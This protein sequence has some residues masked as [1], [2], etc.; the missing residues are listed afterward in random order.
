[1]LALLTDFHYHFKN[2][3]HF[4]LY[5]IYLSLVMNILLFFLTLY[6]QKTDSL[7]TERL[8]AVLVDTVKLQNV[9]LAINSTL[10]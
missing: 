1:M 7:T 4:H 10:T 2:I 3:L 9:H 8:R 5:I 6:K